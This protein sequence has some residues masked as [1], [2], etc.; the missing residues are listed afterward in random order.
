MNRN[1]GLDLTKTICAFMVICI[2]APFPGII[3]EIIIPLTR[4]A[5]PLFFMITGYYYSSTKE[6]KHV[7]K[8]LYK[9]FR[10]FIGANL[11]FLV[12]ILLKSYISNDSI[13]TKIGE[14]FNI[15]S[16]LKFILFNESPF[17]GHLWYLGAI[18]YVLLIIFLFEKKWNREKLYPIVPFL[19]MTDLIFGKYSL[20]LFKDAIPYI[21]VRNFLC[22]GL[23][24]FLIGDWIYTRNIKVKASKARIFIYIFVL[25]T[26]VERLSLEMF[27]ANAIRDHYIST[28]FLSVFTFLLALQHEKIYKSISLTALCNIGAKLSTSIYILHPI[29]ITIITKI[30]TYFSCHIPFINVLY[31]YTAPF[32]IFIFTAIAS[33]IFHEIKKTNKYK[34]LLHKKK[35]QIW[36]LL[37]II[38]YLKLFRKGTE[39]K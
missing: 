29:F 38:V 19:L 37:K 36:L 10:L 39:L 25:T 1:H 8:Q 27:A 7:K 31:S 23:P 6:R 5:V 34:I 33:L 21:L 30:I 24:Y 15:K 9:I 26:L 18:L 20:L 17:C 3:G 11:L 4:I 12:W 14:M 35:I 16:T 28:T 32:V 2:H 13:I 22:V